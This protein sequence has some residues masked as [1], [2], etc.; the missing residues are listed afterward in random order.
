[1]AT[2]DTQEEKCCPEFNP[3]PWQN[4]IVEWH[5]EPFIKASYPSFLHIPLPGAVNRTIT[6]LWQ[7]A[8]AEGIAHAESDFLMLAHDPSPWK[9][10]FYLN[11]KSPAA[12]ADNL[13]LSGK[14]ETLVFDGPYS[15]VP[16]FIKQMDKTLADK[17]MKAS[18]YFFYYTTC[19][20]CAKKYGH[21]YI[22]A[23][24]QVG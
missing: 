7:Q 3:D 23:F 14:F 20:K 16:K 19:P 5:D 2:H 15:H 1:M 13:K 11:V 10:E 18:N 21:N 4:R 12:K 17:S 8:Q 6:K 9:G 24:A 22:V